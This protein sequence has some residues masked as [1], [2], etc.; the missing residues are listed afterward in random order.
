MR[1]THMM[2]SAY[3]AILLGRMRNVPSDRPCSSRSA[4]LRLHRMSHVFSSRWG[5]GVASAVPARPVVLLSM[6]LSRLWWLSPRSNSHLTTTRTQSHITDSHAAT[7]INTS[8]NCTLHNFGSRL[9][10]DSRQ[11]HHSDLRPA[12]FYGSG[13][14]ESSIPLCWYRSTVNICASVCSGTA[15]CLRWRL[16]WRV[17]NVGRQ[18]QEKLYTDTTG[19]LADWR[20]MAFLTQFRFYCAFT[21][22]IYSH[23]LS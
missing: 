8:Q 4:S 21:V 15:H 9:I 16:V 2:D 6:R 19:Q 11:R 18:M 23:N 22:I 1:D 3:G 14:S 7:L 13:R 20:L 5:I 17:A 12:V 10:T